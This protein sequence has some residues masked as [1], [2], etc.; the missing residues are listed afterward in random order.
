M[1]TSLSGHQLHSEP[2]EAPPPVFFGLPP[3]CLNTRCNPLQHQR[4]AGRMNT[5]LALLQ[6]CSAGIMQGSLSHLP[7]CFFTCFHLTSP[8][9]FTLVTLFLFSCRH[10]CLLCSLFLLQQKE[11]KH[12]ILAGRNHSEKQKE[13]IDKT[14]YYF[15]TGSIFF[16]QILYITFT[17]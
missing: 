17:K 5:N 11:L 10:P 15:C 8:S 3:T 7:A 6:H 9:S 16:G 13:K 4:W 2:E 14:C 12:C 1:K